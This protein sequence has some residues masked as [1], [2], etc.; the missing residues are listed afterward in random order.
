MLK[1]QNIYF[2]LDKKSYSWNKILNFQ[3]A[4]SKNFNPEPITNNRK[5]LFNNLNLE[6][7]YGEFVTIIGSN[8]AGKTSLLKLIKG[9]LTQ[10]SGTIEIE[11]KN[12]NSLS[13]KDIS[14]NISWVMQDPKNGTI[15]EMSIFENMLLYENRGKNFPFKFSYNQNRK[16]K[17]QNILNSLKMEFASNID[18]LVSNLSGGQRQALS[19]VMATLT[20]SKLL[21]LDEITAALDP[22][23]TDIVM[24]KAYNIIKSQDLSA[25]MITHNIQHAQKYSDRVLRLQNGVFED[26]TNHAV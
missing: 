5:I 18:T 16:Q 13:K 8:G 22:E 4:Y 20:K 7:G 2:E 19:V 1:L 21:L 11:G 25:I 9:D 15:Q 6:V 12:F 3:K 26:I 23:T 10:D 24:D 17:L 14:K